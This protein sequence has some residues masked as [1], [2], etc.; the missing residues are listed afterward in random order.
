MVKLL[1]LMLVHTPAYRHAVASGP[2]LLACDR[3]E[4][5]ARSPAGS[6]KRGS[7]AWFSAGT[8]ATAR[9]SAAP[10]GRTGARCSARLLLYIPRA[11]T[12]LVPEF[13]SSIR[14]LVS[15]HNPGAEAVAQQLSAAS[16]HVVLD[17]APPA[18]SGIQRR[19]S[20]RRPS[21]HAPV[22]TQ[23]VLL[24]YLTRTTFEGA[25]GD[26]LMSE[27]RHLLARKLPYAMVHEADADAGGCAFGFFFSQAARIDR[28]Q[29]LVDAG[30]FGPLS[31][32]WHAAGDYHVVSVRQALVALGGRMVA[33]S[34][35][36]RRTTVTPGGSGQLIARLKS[37][38]VCSTT[39]RHLLLRRRAP[40][41]H[42]ISAKESRGNGEVCVSEA[43]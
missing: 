9:L 10:L 41:S 18:S 38:L 3:E 4:K 28:L 21:V 7:P 31:V 30:L 26:A 39:A 11:I 27:L 37:G 32:L 1:E 42:A 36:R 12:E 5:S 25:A 17:L 14:L 22:V 15:N 2:D 33:P 29:Q 13:A 16:E 24:L 43:L 40:P 6:A 19:A 34:R 8:P 35:L 23:R 20:Q